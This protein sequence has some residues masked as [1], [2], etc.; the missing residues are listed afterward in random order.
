MI[1]GS[2]IIEIFNAMIYGSNIIIIIIA[3]LYYS[4]IIMI[5][6]IT[7]YQPKYALQY[8]INRP[9]RLL[10]PSLTVEISGTK[11]TFKKIY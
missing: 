7:L 3:I 4:N 10:G 2:N 1:H 5:F 6:N 9:R 8:R 11:I